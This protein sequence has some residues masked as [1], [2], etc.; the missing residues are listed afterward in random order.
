M[1]TLTSSVTITMA[2][3]DAIA[4]CLGPEWEAYVDPRFASEQARYQ[5]ATLR[6]SGPDADLQGAYIYCTCPY[7]SG[8][9]WHWAGQAHGPDG[10]YFADTL[11]EPFRSDLNTSIN[12]SPTKPLQ[13]VAKDIQ[14]RLLTPYLAAYREA[15]QLWR[16]RQEQRT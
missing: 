8:G 2:Q 6:Y 12:C 9:K 16:T 10:A 13:Q 15:L 11:C 4:R 14:R 5:R 7:W 3:A 1:T